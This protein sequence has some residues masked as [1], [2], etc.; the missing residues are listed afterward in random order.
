VAR[1]GMMSALLSKQGP[2]GA[3]RVLADSG[4]DAPPSLGPQM[5]NEPPGH[6][7]TS[8]RD[9]AAGAVWNTCMLCWLY[10]PLLPPNRSACARDAA[11]RS[12][13]WGPNAIPSARDLISSRGASAGRSCRGG[14][15][16]ARVRAEGRRGRSGG[17]LA[18]L[19]E[20]AGL[21]FGEESHG[22]GGHACGDEM[23]PVILSKSTRC[24]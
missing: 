20:G 11:A 8:V 10:P 24:D 22:Q 16:G 13:S 3:M 7:A 6:D 18:A 9:D 12:A 14:S 4:K 23:E 21:W 17:R 5:I 1:G 2:G 19:G 15:S